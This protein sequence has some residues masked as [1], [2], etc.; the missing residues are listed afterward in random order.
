MHAG[1][2]LGDHA[3]LA[4]A[5]CQHDLAKHVVHLVGAGVIEILALEIDLGAAEMRGQPLGEIERRRPADIVGKVAV[6]LL[7]ECRVLLR[8]R[9]RRFKLEDD[10]HQ[11]LGDEA[12]AIISKMPAIVGTGAERIGLALD[13]HEPLATLRSLAL[14][15]LRAARTK[16][17]ILSGS[18]SPG[19][20]ST[21]EETSTPGADVIRSASATLLASRPPESRNGTPGS[22]PSSSRQ[23][24]LLPRP[25]GRVAVRGARASN[26]RRSA[27]LAYCRIGARSARAAIGSALIT[28]NPNRVRT[29]TTRSRVSL[30]CSCSMSGRSASISAASH[31]SEALTASAT[32]RARSRTRPPSARAASKPRWRGDGGKNTKPTASAPASSAASSASGV[33]RP[34]ILI[35]KGIKSS[36]RLV[37]RI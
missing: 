2:G 14:A 21:P 27:T 6:H 30:P 36:S 13:G 32:F 25:P 15:A 26:S 7:L 20:R 9:I 37:R 16:A 12:A 34:Q 23:S 35:N 8:R 31:S 5:A 11:C 1:A 24:K 28:G 17:R 4:H 22:I 3:R 18:F 29:I 10:R 19:A 33:L